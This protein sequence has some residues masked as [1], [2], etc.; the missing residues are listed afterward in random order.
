MVPDKAMACYGLEY[1]CFEGDGLWDS[2]NEELIK[3]A[4]KEMSTIGLLDP[5]DVRDGYVVRQ[6]KAYP[7]SDHLYKKHLQT[8]REAAKAY[9]GLEFMGRNGMHMYNN[10]DHSMMTAMLASKNIIA[11]KQIYDVWT[12]NEDAE[13]HEGGNRGESSS[14]SGQRYVPIATAP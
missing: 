13:Y 9:K 3:L 14:T 8:I 6:P 1:F 12:V 2:S 11:G 5:H 10:Q 7:V 4:T